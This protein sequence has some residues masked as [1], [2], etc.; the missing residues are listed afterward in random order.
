MHPNKAEIKEFLDTFY[1]ST[2]IGVIYIDSYLNV[3]ASS[4]GKNI[5]D[6]FICLEAGKITAFLTEK[7]SEIPDDNN[8]MHTFYLDDDLISMVRLAV[9]DNR[10]AGAYVTHPVFIRKLDQNEMDTMLDQFSCSLKERSMIREVLLGVPVM[11]YESVISS[12]NLLS[13][14]S[15]D[16]TLKP[17]RQVLHHIGGLKDKKERPAAPP[18]AKHDEDKGEMY[19]NR[20]YAFYF[21]MKDSIQSGDPRDI[22]DILDEVKIGVALWKQ[23]SSEEFLPALR[24]N[25]IKILSAA[26]FMAVEAGAQFQKTMQLAD[27]Y[28]RQAQMLQNTDA[29]YSLLKTALNTFTRAVSQNHAVVYSKPVR[30]VLDHITI[31]YQEKITLEKLAEVTKL[32]TYYLSNLIKKE[33]GLILAEHISRARVEQGKKLL[34]KTNMSILEIAQEVGYNYQNHFT[35]VFRRQTGVTPT[36]YK[37]M[38]SPDQISSDIENTQSDTIPSELEITYYLLF[39]LNGTYDTAR[40][41]DPISKKSWMISPKGGLR[42]GP[43]SFNEYWDKNDSLA[44]KAIESQKIGFTIKEY[45]GGY[46]FI[47]AVAQK[48]NKKTYAIEVAKRITSQ[49]YKHFKTLCQENAHLLTEEVLIGE[50]QQNHYIQSS[51]IEKLTDHMQKNKDKKKHITIMLAVIEG[52]ALSDDLMEEIK[53]ILSCSLRN[54]R[55]WIGNYIGNIFFVTLDDISETVANTI[56]NRLDLNIRIALEKKKIGGEIRVRFALKTISS[57]IT[58]PGAMIRMAFMSLYSEIAV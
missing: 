34:R 42:P 36:E 35:S 53:T 11:P 23:Y 7:F 56:K 24:R 16:L 47:F 26:C 13:I 6:M 31:H 28:I 29:G 17:G 3:I 12:G 10:Y 44:S 8:I 1:Q 49:A 55:D 14:L 43:T 27:E 19:W 33:T 46:L 9:R 38:N 2:S 51:I 32:S 39:L 21:K 54:E 40:I 30:Q 48:I 58:D 37:C 45:S 52:E 5:I 57:D 4:P 20:I 15:R 41:V 18:I 50:E 25:F 22:Q